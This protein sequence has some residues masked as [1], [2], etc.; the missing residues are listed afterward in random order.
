MRVCAYVRLCICMYLCVP[1]RCLC[2]R[3]YVCVYMLCVYVCIH[4]CL[5]TCIRVYVCGQGCDC[6]TSLRQPFPPLICNLSS[7]LC[8]ISSHIPLTLVSYR[9]IF[10]SLSHRCS[11]R[12]A[13]ATN[14]LV[15]HILTC[16]FFP[17][18]AALAPAVPVSLATERALWVVRLLLAP[19]QRRP[20]HHA[21]RLHMR[22]A[23]RGF[24]HA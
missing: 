18:C 16:L 21:S 20:R 11:R 8:F 19:R 9:H 3:G 6:S 4:V 22:H 7:M 14:L 5:C 10:R 12:H 2:V 1:I 24:M 15:L 23:L 13:W 17:S